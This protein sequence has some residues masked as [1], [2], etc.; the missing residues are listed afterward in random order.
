MLATLLALVPQTQ[1]PLQAPA[2]A[3][4]RVSLTAKAPA[5]GE[6]IAW[7]P[8]GASVALAKNGDVLAGTFALGPADAPPVRVE[9]SSSPGA[10][11]VDRL[12]IDCN[13]DG[14]FGDD[15]RFTTT[16]KEQRGKWW[17]S[18]TATVQLPF[19]SGASAVRQPYPMDLWFVADPQE[20]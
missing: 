5:D 11:H 16:P 9:L 18:F 20:P 13:R 4:L 15:E 8:K 17:S 19:G 6:R 7:S 3:P 2:P 12:A 14:R 10:E 1:Q